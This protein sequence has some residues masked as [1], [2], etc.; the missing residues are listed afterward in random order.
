MTSKGVDGGGAKG[1]ALSATMEADTLPKLPLLLLEL[2]GFT[3]ADPGG[4]GYGV[5]VA[6]S[7]LYVRYPGRALMSRPL[8]AARR[9]QFPEVFTC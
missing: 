6:G 7:W 8:A 5:Q 9:R 4:P 1:V 3:A 2:N